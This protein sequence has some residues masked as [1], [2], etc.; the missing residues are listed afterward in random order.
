M[1]MLRTNPIETIIMVREKNVKLL[2]AVFL[3]TVLSIKRYS[4]GLL[5]QKMPHIGKGTIIFFCSNVKLTIAS[6][7]AR[8]TW[9]CRPIRI[10]CKS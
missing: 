1:A 2:Q 5:K 9:Y 10:R 8:H 4:K 3:V 6:S 7:A